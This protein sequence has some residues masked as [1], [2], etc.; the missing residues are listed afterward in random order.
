MLLCYVT[1]RTLLDP[2]RRNGALLQSIKDVGA[3]GVDWIQIREK[4]LSA[5][6][7]LDLARHAIAA[8][9]RSTR[10]LINDRL[11]V[12]IGAGAAGVHLGAASIP[13]AETVRWC[14]AGKAPKDFRIGVSCHSLKEAIAAEQAGASYVFFGPVYDTPSKI[15][16][17][18][19]QGIARLAE[20]CKSVKIPILA[21]GGIDEGNAAE[22]L[23]AGAAGIAAIR[24]FQE[25]KD[26]AALSRLVA[27]LRKLSAVG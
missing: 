8:V 22:C 10:I 24:L 26:A 20:V 5:R 9:P 16:F 15:Q 2:S 7:L 21:I 13:V 23:Q 19:P 25:A 17:G 3:A 11:D 4:D 1:D 14:S 6:E 27:R 18:A 12:A